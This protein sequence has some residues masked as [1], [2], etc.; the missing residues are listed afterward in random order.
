[1][2]L[3]THLLATFALGLIATGVLIGFLPGGD[4]GAAFSGGKK[5]GDPDGCSLSRAE[6]RAV[7]LALIGL[8]VTAGAASAVVSES[9]L[10]QRKRSSV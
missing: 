6:R 4:C 2:R 9:R 5:F 7:P 1:M 8:G 10:N 3:L